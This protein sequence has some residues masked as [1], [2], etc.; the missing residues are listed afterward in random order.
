MSFAQQLKN[1]RNALNPNDRTQEGF[2]HDFAKVRRRDLSE[3]LYHFDRLDNT[4]RTVH[5]ADEICRVSIATSH[6]ETLEDAD[7]LAS[8]MKDAAQKLREACDAHAVLSQYDKVSQM[9][10]TADELD[11]VIEALKTPEGDG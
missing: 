9:E 7:Y 11:A 5:E 4:A 8:L 2:F 3:L 6:N 1:L 10:A